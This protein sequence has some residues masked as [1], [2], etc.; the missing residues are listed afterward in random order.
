MQNLQDLPAS[1]S[2]RDVMT[3]P[4]ADA[5]VKV[6]H[7]N[8]NLFRWALKPAG[9]DLLNSFGISAHGHG[10]QSH[11]HPIHKTYETDLLFNR[12]ASRADVDS[13]VLYMKP[14]KFAKL[15]AINSNFKC[16]IN[17]HHVALDLNRYP[18]HNQ[19]PITTKYAFMHDALM[20][21]SPAKIAGLFEDSPKL[22][23]MWVSL[24]HPVEAQLGFRSFLPQLYQTRVR[25][26]TLDY[27]LEGS[28]DGAYSQP[29]S[30][31]DW[32]SI[33]GISTQKFQLS[34]TLTSTQGPFHELLISRKVL[35]AE[36]ARTFYHPESI[37]LP[38]PHHQELPLSHRLV[39]R[40]IKDMLLTY[41]RAVRTLRETDPMA[42]IR[43]QQPKAEFAWVAPEAWLNLCQFM[44]NL[45]D[46]VPK[47]DWKQRLTPWAKLKAWVLHHLPI[48]SPLA[49]MGASTTLALKP[50]LAE[51]FWEFR[52]S[53]F[54]LLRI[55]GPG[56]LWAKVLQT[57]VWKWPGTFWD[58]PWHRALYFTARPRLILPTFYRAAYTDDGWISGQFSTAPVKTFLGKITDIAAVSLAVTLAGFAIWKCLNH[59]DQVAL[60]AELTRILYPEPFVLSLNTQVV[61]VSP[62]P[63]F[64]RALLPLAKL[65]VE[66]VPDYALPQPQPDPTALRSSAEA[67]STAPFA[68]QDPADS[69][70][71]DDWVP[72]TPPERVS[73]M[74]PVPDTPP[75]PNLK[76]DPPPGADKL[77]PLLGQQ[78]SLESSVE[79]LGMKNQLKPVREWHPNLPW[80]PLGG[81]NLT[82][83]PELTPLKVFKGPDCLLVALS[84]S[85]G[86]S[87]A[88]IWATL[89][90][91]YAHNALEDLETRSFGLSS[92]HLE[93]LAAFYR[94]KVHVVSD[95]ATMI[96]GPDNANP[97]FLRHQGA[98]DKGHWVS[99]SSSDFPRGAVLRARASPLRSLI[100]S[101][102][103]PFPITKIRKLRP[104]PHRAKILLS[105]M[106]YGHDGVFSSL[107]GNLK[108]DPTEIMNSWSNSI[109]TARDPVEMV[110]I[111]GF[112]GCGKSYAVARALK[113]RQDYVVASPTTHLRDS[114]KTELGLSAQRDTWRSSTW[115]MALT[116]SS[117]ILVIDEV[118]KLPPGYLDL[119]LYANRGVTSLIVLGDPLQG[120]YHPTDPNSTLGSLTPEVDRLKPFADVYCF[121]TR[122]LNQATA[123]A[124][125]VHTESSEKGRVRSFDASTP[126]AKLT[127]VPAMDTAAALD[128]LG[129]TALTAAG[130]QGLTINS[131]VGIFLDA[132]TPLM[133]PN[134]ALVAITRSR[135]DIIWS[136]DGR[137]LHN[138]A[139]THPFS[140]LVNATANILASFPTLLNDLIILPHPSCLP[141]PRLKVRGGLRPRDAPSFDP[142]YEGDIL[143]DRRH[144]LRQTGNPL[145]P[146][147]DDFFVPECKRILLHNLED[148]SPETAA[149]TASS[150]TSCEPEPVYPGCDYEC[151]RH[152]YARDKAPMEME[153]MIDGELSNQF[154]HLNEP[155]E[156]EVESPSLVAPIHNPRADPTLLKSSIEKRLR[157]TTARVSSISPR[158]QIAG[159]LLF[160]AYHDALKL[161]P[162]GPAFD[163]VLFAS[164]ISENEYIQLT[165][166][167]RAIII[168]NAGRSDPE[169]D[170]TMARIFPKSQH[171]ININSLLS[172]WKACQTLALL[173]DSVVLLLGPVKKYQRAMVKACSKNP[174]IFVYGGKSPR[175][176]SLFAQQ[177][178]PKGTKRVANDYTAF[179]QSQRGESTYFEMRKMNYFNLPPEFADF[180]HFLKMNLKCQFGR[181]A[182]MRFTG[183]PGTYDDN[184]DF[185][186]AILNLEYNLSG[187]PTMVSGDDSLLAWHPPVRDSWAA[188]SEFFQLLT[189]KKE[190]S[191]YGEFC[192]YYVSHCGA[193]RAPRP[194]LIKLALSEARDEL[195]K[196]L[197]SYVAEFSVGHSLGDF[198][199]A[200]LPA[201]EV[202]YQSAVYDFICRKASPELKVMLKAG[203]VP[204]D[205]LAIMDCAV[206]R[207][208]FSLLNAQQRWAYIR[209]KRPQFMTWAL[210]LRDTLLSPC[211]ERLVGGLIA[212]SVSTQPS[213]SNSHLNEMSQP[214]D[215]RSPAPAAGVSRP[216]LPESSSVRPY[217]VPAAPPAASIVA[218][219]K[220]VAPGLTRPFQH[221][222][223]RYHANATTEVNTLPM[224][225]LAP[226]TEMMSIAR[227]G[228]LVELAVIILPHANVVKHAC[229][230]DVAWSPSEIIPTKSAICSLPNSRR[231]LFGGVSALNPVEIICDL[232]AFNPTLKGPVTYNGTPRLSVS[233]TAGEGPNTLPSVDIYIRGKIH[234]SYP[235]M[236]IG[237]T[238][239]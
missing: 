139:S 143:L 47:L 95:N 216:D 224:M 28:A 117:K 87:K 148:A 104:D 64:T 189:W 213:S 94:W 40:E 73:L 140:V 62:E 55:V 158:E 59:Q 52:P 42:F 159:A 53:F 12:W 90:S 89:S 197:P 144:P 4:I 10:L 138:L 164:C 232:T 195:H 181:L 203:E 79:P 127:L 137:I 206:S 184:T 128:S 45:A 229:H 179:D 188:C 93:Y 131:N 196:T 202:L 72:S 6:I 2:Q 36:G 176:M 39:P 44:L 102:P 24:V 70:G 82:T 135:R 153:K 15:S 108:L 141:E 186:L 227:V 25:D 134:V 225:T 233:F 80:W 38:Q 182:P 33:S 115:E 74:V 35:P 187:V 43:T 236:C 106:R 157:F 201:S 77:P 193:V 118:Y 113:G 155:F 235:E 13:T 132:H 154:P 215:H 199:W 133:S 162:R 49:L 100:Q 109:T 32:L 30:C 58:I 78:L 142:S 238:P 17:Q 163:P 223:H 69:S 167:T 161:P 156:L 180:H 212:H 68:S 29:L 234:L 210:D 172:E 177:H 101:S 165:S 183:E 8:V 114:W 67:H 121:W 27:Y 61:D 169:L 11:P 129:H 125:G 96:F 112:A 228:Q 18:E 126:E 107:T 226:L 26:G 1:A 66:P 37:L 111:Q 190:H 54:R 218:V 41:T 168:A 185:N 57:P 75:L 103:I 194:L 151:L 171:K 81:T 63:F 239:A 130:S 219:D 166:K 5:A 119:A 174:L 110:L 14:A 150:P 9:V 147:V 205:I 46:E 146:L 86:L 85:T 170:V 3:Q 145:I 50:F 22:E 91:G 217:S 191:L 123:Q 76:Q 16:L 198:L 105:N 65:N 7:R 200:A 98:F 175:D 23:K 20:Y 116:R 221:W 92:D 173:H 99:I 230:I 84:E 211:K 122:R 149:A 83:Q 207:P 231:L 34:V 51:R 152:E 160:Q 21:I 136:G 214:V 60:N 237:N 209:A 88:S 222:I 71:L 56:R 124:L 19:G 192:G 120:S 97:I 31:H 48:W 178:F 220:T 204:D 208:V